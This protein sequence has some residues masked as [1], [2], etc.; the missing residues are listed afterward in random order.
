MVLPTH[1]TSCLS[2]ILAQIAI[3][4][5]RRRITITVLNI[6]ALSLRLANSLHTV[7]RSIMLG[8]AIND[9][10][11]DFS[12]GSVTH[13]HS[14]WSTVEERLT[15]RERRFLL[16]Y[17]ITTNPVL[18][19]LQIKLLCFTQSSYWRHLIWQVHRD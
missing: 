5:Y 19:N 6:A 15:C 1:N 10:P 11:K 16:N 14:V 13:R 3:S 2:W 18:S 8:G 12:L 4:R 17:I 9:T 7:E